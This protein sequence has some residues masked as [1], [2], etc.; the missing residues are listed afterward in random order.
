[1]ARQKRKKFAENE[2]MDNI[3]QPGKGNFGK[4]KGK[5]GKVGRC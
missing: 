1:M 4:L 3:V 5:W 2:L